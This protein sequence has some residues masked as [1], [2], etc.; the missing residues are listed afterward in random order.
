MVIDLHAEHNHETIKD[1]DKDED[2][3]GDVSEGSPD[4]ENREEIVEA[5]AG[6]LGVS[7]LNQPVLID[8]LS[9]IGQI[10]TERDGG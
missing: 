7:G 1:E 10:T 2:K 8:I 3:I 9:D 5:V 4:G 6:S